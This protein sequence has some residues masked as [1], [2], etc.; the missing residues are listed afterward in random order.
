M[1]N[2]DSIKQVLDNFSISSIFVGIGGLCVCRDTRKHRQTTHRISPRMSRKHMSVA[3][4]TQI[5]IYK[6]INNVNLIIEDYKN[7][8][9]RIEYEQETK[10]ACTQIR[11][12][13]V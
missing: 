2:F 7:E 9:T 10:E 3:G 5:W 4:T 6:N 8:G 1:C 13:P 12:R 11:S